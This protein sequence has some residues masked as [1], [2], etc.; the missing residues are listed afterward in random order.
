MAR[1]WG[2]LFSK[3]GF[4]ALQTVCVAVQR[5]SDSVRLTNTASS[6]G[7]EIVNDLSVDGKKSGT[8]LSLCCGK[9]V[10]ENIG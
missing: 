9:E 1:N 10:T 5:A 4:G 8:R 6:E 7:K 3:W 2:L